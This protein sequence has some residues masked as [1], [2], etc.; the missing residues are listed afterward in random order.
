MEYKLLHVF[1][2]GIEGNSP[3]MKI[4]IK[5]VLLC[6]IKQKSAVYPNETKSI[7]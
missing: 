1:F 7:L 4:C 3:H 5:D 2:S 6:G